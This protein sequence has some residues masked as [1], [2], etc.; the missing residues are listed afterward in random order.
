M[1][2]SLQ[3]LAA[4][5]AH[6]RHHFHRRSAT[7]FL[8]LFEI[9]ELSSGFVYLFLFKSMLLFR[10]FHVCRGRCEHGLVINFLS[11]QFCETNLNTLQLSLIRYCL[12][13]EIGAS[14]LIVAAPRTYAASLDFNGSQSVAHGADFPI[15][16]IS[17]I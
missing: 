17:T 16:R 10:E 5:T 15:D 8:L 14:L 1:I 3:N 12:G 2:L 4:Q 13:C 11:C 7:Q 9:E 6:S